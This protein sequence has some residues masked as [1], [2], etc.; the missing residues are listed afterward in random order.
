MNLST[1]Y[2]I[3]IVQRY[4]F[5]NFIYY[6]NTRNNGYNKITT[7]SGPLDSAY[8]M[9]ETCTKIYHYHIKLKIELYRFV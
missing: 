3:A 2:N 6:Q 7:E 5:I 8:T 4:F 1:G 9:C